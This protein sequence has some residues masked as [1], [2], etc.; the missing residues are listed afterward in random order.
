MVGDVVVFRLFV[1]L[2]CIRGIIKLFPSHLS[3]DNDLVGGLLLLRLAKDVYGPP[4]LVG[5][6]WDVEAARLVLADLLDLLEVVVGKLDLL[7]VITNA[8]E[9]PTRS[10]ISLM[11]LWVM[12]RGSPTMLL[13]KAEYSVT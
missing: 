3:L 11:V 6:V 9:A 8:G 2:F 7:E 1:P 13:P 5:S 10:A 12:S 4:G